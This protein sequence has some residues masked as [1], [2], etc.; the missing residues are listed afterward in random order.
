[1]L[2]K[3]LLLT[4]TLLLQKSGKR[5][6]GVGAGK[7]R[8]RQMPKTD[9]QCGKQKHFTIIDLQMLKSNKKKRITT[10]YQHTLK[11]YIDIDNPTNI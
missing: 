6:T 2:A 7:E 5:E 11:R 1:M 3:M 9:L 8:E 4:N 10:K